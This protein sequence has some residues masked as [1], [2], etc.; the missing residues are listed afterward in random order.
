MISHFFTR[1][2]FSSNQIFYYM[3]ILFLIQYHNL[4]T[5]LPRLFQKNKNQ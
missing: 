4:A 2:F 5:L 1:P 3:Y